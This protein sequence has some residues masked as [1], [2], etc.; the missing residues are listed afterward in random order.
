MRHNEKDE[1]KRERHEGRNEER[2]REP[3]AETVGRGARSD[4]QSTHEEEIRRG[5]K[6]S[7]NGRHGENKEGG[8]RQDAREIREKISR[9]SSLTEE[10]EEEERERERERRSREEKQRA[11]AEE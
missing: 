2:K 11:G 5:E 8:W 4:E 3:S 10:E 9:E 6:K 1:R 7:R